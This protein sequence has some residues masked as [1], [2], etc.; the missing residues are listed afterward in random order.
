[1]LYI[2]NIICIVELFL[3]YLNSIEFILFLVGLIILY[4]HIIYFFK[5]KKYLA[6][7]KNFKD[8]ETIT[9]DDLKSIPLVNFIIPAWNEG[10]AFEDCLISITKLNYPNIKVIIN[11][12]GSD[13]TLRIVNSF[14]SYKNFIVL[15]QEKGLYLI[16]GHNKIRALNQ[17]FD[18]VS[19]GLLFL[20]DA[21]CYITD[22]ILLRMIYPI[23]NNGKDLVCSGVRPLKSQESI[24]LVKYVDLSRFA[25]I[26]YK[27]TRYTYGGITGANACLTYNVIKKIGRFSEN[28]LII[29]EHSRGSDLANHG[30]SAYNLIDY[31]SWIYT[32]YPMK[33]KELYNQRKRFIMYKFLYSLQIKHLKPL[34]S[35]LIIF[36]ISVYVLLLPVMFFMHLGLFTLGILF[37]FSFYLKKIRKYLA[38]KKFL[39]VEYYLKFQLKFFLKMLIYIYI[40][41]IFNIKIMMGLISFIL[42]YKRQKIRQ[43]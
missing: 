39:G 19:E 14:K 35:I 4:H 42:K 17:C 11:A 7:A 26:N 38:F 32:E 23:I 40:E 15:K 34:L 24:D 8:L 13:E 12:G 27:F 3:Q 25:L 31:R 33:L 37:I 20:I 9:I 1:M 6:I 28:K 2:Q 29:E 36:A 21:D 41:M 10:K 18:Y 43:I 22:E 30:F 5:D 16:Q